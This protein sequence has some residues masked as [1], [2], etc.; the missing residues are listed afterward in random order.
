MKMSLNK[1]LKEV[2]ITKR[3]KFNKMRKIHQNFQPLL[4]LLLEKLIISIKKKNF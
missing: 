3:H 1:P 2:K 4:D